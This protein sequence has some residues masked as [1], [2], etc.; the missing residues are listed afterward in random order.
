MSC[1]IW[2]KYKITWK[3]KIN[4]YQLIVWYYHR[5]VLYLINYFMKNFTVAIKFVLNGKDYFLIR[6]LEKYFDTSNNFTF[7]HFYQENYAI[8]EYKE[9]IKDLIIVE[10]WHVEGYINIEGIK[11]ITNLK[12]TF[13]STLTK[14]PLNSI[15]FIEWGVYE[16]YDNE[17][18]AIFRLSFSRRIAKFGS[19]QVQIPNVW[20]ISIVVFP[21]KIIAKSFIEN[22]VNN[23]NMHFPEAVIDNE[24]RKFW[25][26]LWRKFE[27]SKIVSIA[28]HL[29]YSKCF[30]K[31]EKVKESIKKWD[32]DP[33]KHSLDDNLENYILERWWFEKIDNDEILDIFSKKK[34]VDIIENQYILWVLL[35]FKEKYWVE[36]FDTIILRYKN[37]KVTPNVTTNAPQKLMNHPVYYEL[38]S[39]YNYYRDTKASSYVFDNEIDTRLWADPMRSFT[40]LYE[41]YCLIQFQIFLKSIWVIFNDTL[42]ERLYDKKLKTMVRYENDPTKGFL[43]W[44]FKSKKIRL[45][46]WDKLTFQN[47]RWYRLFDES[48]DFGFINK[49]FK[50]VSEGW[51][52]P[53]ITLE[54]DDKLLICD[55]KFSSFRDFKSKID[56]P[57]P[58][59]FMEGLQKYRR[60]FVDDNINNSPIVIFYPWEVSKDNLDKFKLMHEL[61]LQ[62]YNMYLFPIH[63]STFESEPLLAYLKNRF[64]SKDVF[65]LE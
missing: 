44:Y 19:E 30:E 37:M 15:F 52:T 4:S 43:N 18:N 25:K 53:D 31:T 56:F 38:I 13:E 65:P 57:N 51:I 39:L 22:I 35:F 10:W 24:W 63:T 64:L 41:I 54:T 12:T 40:E 50:K 9:K 34:V 28:R 60:V 3:Y 32:Y 33:I 61:T 27:L 20:N 14:E 48:H 45:Y 55:V 1:N 42:K 23:I 49:R 5:F 11:N 17:Y 2:N 47:S 16:V 26:V 29:E 59:Y 36:I 21:S 62:S 8:F 6:K 7:D 46:Y 58:T